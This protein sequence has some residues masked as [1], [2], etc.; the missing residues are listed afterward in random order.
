MIS[1]NQYR[2][3]TRHSLDKKSFNTVKRDLECSVLEHHPAMEQDKLMSREATGGKNSS[4]PPDE[5]QV[6]MERLEAIMSQCSSEQEFKN[7]LAQH[8]IQYKYTPK[9]IT[10]T[11]P[12]AS[13]KKNVHRL[14]T[15]GLQERY[16]EMLLRG[17]GSVRPIASPR[18]EVAEQELDVTEQFLTNES[19]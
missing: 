12:E 6:F 5:K 18:A 17:E 4:Q 16:D 3:T 10:L 8:G 2:Q 7:L 11:N 9:N 14:K 13:Y 1:A 19:H 15:L